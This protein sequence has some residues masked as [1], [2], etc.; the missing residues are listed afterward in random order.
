MLLY[1]SAISIGQYASNLKVSVI[2]VSLIKLSEQTA[3]KEHSEQLWLVV[4]FISHIAVNCRK[5][6]N[7]LF[8]E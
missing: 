8:S 7:D 4:L 6:C 2:L 5:S 3:E 1:L